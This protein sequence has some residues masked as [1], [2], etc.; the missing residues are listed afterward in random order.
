MPF[1]PYMNR[2]P[3]QPADEV[4]DCGRPADDSD[5]WAERE[6]ERQQLIK[7]NWARSLRARRAAEAKGGGDGG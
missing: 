4:D 5:P 1:Q 2:S 6:Y 3:M 7:D